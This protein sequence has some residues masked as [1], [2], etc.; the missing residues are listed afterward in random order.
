MA[1]AIIRGRVAE[2]DSVTWG[3]CTMRL[4]G[5]VRQ[6][7]TVT[8]VCGALVAAGTAPALANNKNDHHH[9]WWGYLYDQMQSLTRSLGNLGGRVTG[10]LD[11]LSKRVDEL[12][13]TVAG[14]ANSSLA[15][16]IDQ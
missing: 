13:A 10:R 1:L 8:L 5:S 9:H 2:Q 12:A 3:G 4:S 11:Y 16:R 15:A 7:A 14:Q 6:I